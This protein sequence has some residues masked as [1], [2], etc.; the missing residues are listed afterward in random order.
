MSDGTE[1]P[2]KLKALV[3]DDVEV[4]HYAEW[5]SKAGAA[6]SPI[7]AVETVFDKQNAEWVK[8]KPSR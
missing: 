8:L 6:I 3:C 5:R 2:S 1:L 7:M 4:H